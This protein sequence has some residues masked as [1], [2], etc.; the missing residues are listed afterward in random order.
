MSPGFGI[1]NY[2]VLFNNQKA[3]DIVSFS[4]IHQFLQLQ[5]RTQ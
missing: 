3:L 2:A 4:T 5:K 1:G